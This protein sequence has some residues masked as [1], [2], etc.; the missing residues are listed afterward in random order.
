MEFLKIFTHQNPLSHRKLD[1][2]WR[3]FFA[4]N[5]TNLLHNPLGNMIPKR[6]MQFST[7]HIY[8]MSP[9]FF[10][11]CN[12]NWLLYCTEFYTVW[13]VLQLHIWH[14]LG[15]SGYWRKVTSLW[16]FLWVQ[17]SVNH[18]V[19]QSWP[20]SFSKIRKIG[21]YVC[22][23]PILKKKWKVTAT[24]RQNWVSAE[25]IIHTYKM[26]SHWQSFKLPSK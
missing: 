11:P 13:A 20:S 10:L 25:V 24:Y 3:L 23:C 18:T 1:K 15:Q 21:M 26:V 5:G 17:S 9:D 6:Q 12:S 2:S 14:A 8:N 4:K 19:S 22:F 16:P 7:M